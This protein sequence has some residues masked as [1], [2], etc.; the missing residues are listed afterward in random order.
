MTVSQRSRQRIGRKLRPKSLELRIHRTGSHLRRELT[1]LH[2]REVIRVV[3][4]DALAD[5]CWHIGRPLARPA[6]LI[7]LHLA[8]AGHAYEAFETARFRDEVGGA[9]AEQ[10]R[11][12]R[13]G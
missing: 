10:A 6:A 5:E 4:H 9:A 3:A 8:E 7:A 13:D 2:R 1:R 12:R 11:N